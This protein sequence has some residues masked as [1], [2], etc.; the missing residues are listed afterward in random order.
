MAQKEEFR[1][2]AESSLLGHI[3]LFYFEYEDYRF[4]ESLSRT[5]DRGWIVRMVR[6][7]RE[8]LAL[9]GN[10]VIVVVAAAA[11]AFRAAGKPVAGVNLN[12]RL[13]RDDFQQAAALRSVK[14]GRSLELAG[15]SPVYNP[16]VI[17]S[18][19]ISESREIG[20]DIASESFATTKSIGVPATGSLSPTG[21]RESSV[22]R[23]SDA[24]SLSS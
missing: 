8:M 17:I 23:Y 11:F 9:Y 24:L 22:G 20:L 2:N 16:A 4:F 10:T 6:R 7:I 14:F 1:I 12:T 21:I 15:F 19:S 3:R 13:C 18:F 5:E